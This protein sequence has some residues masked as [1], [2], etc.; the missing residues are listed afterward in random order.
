[1]SDQVGNHDERFSQNEAQISISEQR[2]HVYLHRKWEQKVKGLCDQFGQSSNGEYMTV[3]GANT[4]SSSEFAASWNVDKKVCEDVY[5]HSDY[6]VCVRMQ[7]FL[8]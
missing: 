2:V 7:L 3:T 8:S 1:M 6:T 4:T 5:D